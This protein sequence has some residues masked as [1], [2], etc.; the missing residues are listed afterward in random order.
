PA[1]EE[2]LVMQG[3]SVF[4]GDV[5][6]EVLLSLEIRNEE[7]HPS[8]FRGAVL[9]GEW[10]ELTADIGSADCTAGGSCRVPPSGGACS[11]CNYPRAYAHP[12][13]L[14]DAFL[15]DQVYVG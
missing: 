12:S 2:I 5:G 14:L 11:G 9:L 1:Q 7:F 3:D 4:L 10:S 6:T 8:S 15:V 13:S